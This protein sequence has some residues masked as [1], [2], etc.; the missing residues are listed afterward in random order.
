MLTPVPSQINPQLSAVWEDTPMQKFEWL[1]F[2][3]TFFNLESQATALFKKVSETYACNAANVL[4]LADKKPVVAWLSALD[5]GTFVT[6]D[7]TYR[8]QLLLDAG[9]T[10]LI[11][12]SVAP[13][14]DVQTSIMDADVL[15]D[16]TAGIQTFS[17]FLTVYGL[18]D[19]NTGTASKF[20]FL[21]NKKVF[22]TDRKR[23]SFGIDDFAQSSWGMPDLVQHGW[24]RER[25]DPVV[26][27]FLS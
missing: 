9:V 11:S 15:I 19:N 21:A 25:S 13:L 23:N 18:K 7:W 27:E 8:T 3:S 17:D 2:I 24:F 6:V 22:K 5:D 14:S 26:F 12:P 4:K 16:D 20:K 10:A 1:L